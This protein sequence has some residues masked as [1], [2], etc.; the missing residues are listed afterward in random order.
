[1]KEVGKNT[2]NG[3]YPYENSH[4]CLYKR[5]KDIYDSQAS[6]PFKKACHN[7][8]FFEKTPRGFNCLLCVERDAMLLTNWGDTL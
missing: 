8:L 5:Q 3:C 4:F 7:K 1:M 6:T 2:Q